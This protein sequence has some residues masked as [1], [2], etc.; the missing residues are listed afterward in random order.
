MSWYKILSHDLHCG[1]L[2]YR[3]LLIPLFMLFPCMLCY[4]ELH[5]Q[6]VTGNWMDY[7]LY[8]FRGQAYYIVQDGS[9]S[10]RIPTIWILNVGACLYLNLDY[11]IN[12]LTHAGQQIIIRCNRKSE[13]FLSK[14]VWNVSSCILY[15]FILSVFVALFV[16]LF[17][18]ALTVNSSEQA[19]LIIFSEIL[20][21]PIKLTVLQNV[22]L[23]IISPLLTIITLN[24]MEM[25]LC[26]FV[27]PAIGF[28]MSLSVL[29][30]SIFTQPSCIPGNGAMA[31]RSSILVDNGV[32]WESVFISSIILIGLSILVGV[33]Y[34]KYKDTLGFEE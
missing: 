2:R 23:G 27:K 18:G 30:L 29:G 14:C 10:L 1:L 34:F 4:R 28:L 3:Y 20:Y 13:W 19:N 5:Q 21:E 26:L 32:R 16:L 15:Y 6:G 31:I 22:W 7:M 12:D 9:I 8:C 25:V 24:I 17:G 11:L 33:T